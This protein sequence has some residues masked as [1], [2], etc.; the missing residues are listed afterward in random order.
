M[1][2]GPRQASLRTELS[3]G[4]GQGLRGHMVPGRVGCELRCAEG[5]AGGEAAAWRGWGVG[6]QNQVRQRSCSIP[7][8]VAG[9]TIA[10]SAGRHLPHGRAQLQHPVP[11]SCAELARVRQQLPL[12]LSACLREGVRTGLWV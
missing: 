9:V 1:S 10:A 3:T 5:R 6:G 11:G 7:L 12:G 4:A 2:T 8:Q